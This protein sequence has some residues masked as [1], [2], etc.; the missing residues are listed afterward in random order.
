MALLERKVLSKKETRTED[1][2]GLLTLVGVVVALGGCPTNVVSRVLGATMVNCTTPPAAR[3]APP[4][5][6][7][8]NGDEM[9]FKCSRAEP[10]SFRVVAATS[11]HPNRTKQRARTFP[12]PIDVRDWA[13]LVDEHRPLMDGS[14]GWSVA[15]EATTG[16]NNLQP[17]T[18][19][20]SGNQFGCTYANS[21][22]N[23]SV[24]VARQPAAAAVLFLQCLDGIYGANR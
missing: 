8:A 21:A 17:A 3:A 7:I 16:V 6:C 19:T 5:A 23:S 11:Q 4:K 22:R 24:V 2:A 20:S 13:F 15:D 18:A 10:V 9:G 1:D 12:C 14:E